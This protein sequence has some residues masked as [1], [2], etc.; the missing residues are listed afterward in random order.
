MYGF[1]GMKTTVFC[2]FPYR[3]IY[4]DRCAHFQLNNFVEKTHSCC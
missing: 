1:N 4:R 3:K 2:I